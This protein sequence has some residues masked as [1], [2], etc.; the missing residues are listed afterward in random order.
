MV[1]EVEWKQLGMESVVTRWSDFEPS[2]ASRPPIYIKKCVVARHEALL[3]VFESR[4]R[5]QK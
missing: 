5:H 1:L 2:C 4:Q 3:L